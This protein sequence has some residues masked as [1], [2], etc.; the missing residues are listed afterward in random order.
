MRI[1][2]I[3]KK[4]S[5]AV[6]AHNKH[7]WSD[8]RKRSKS[9]LIAFVICIVVVLGYH[10]TFTDAPKD[11]YYKGVSV[12]F[13]LLGISFFLVWHYYLTS[14]S[15]W[16]RVKSILNSMDKKEVIVKYEINSEGFIRETPNARNQIKWSGFNN[17]SVSENFIVF[18]GK[19]DELVSDVWINKS[20]IGEDDL[21]LLLN[22]LKDIFN[23][24]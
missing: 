15:F 14:S 4:P 1:T 24:V 16:S 19:N 23:E 10:Y 11:V 8:E 3:D 7:L 5:I 2:I 21:E 20:C 12:A 18:V 13:I 6:K 22:N 9:R 17:Y